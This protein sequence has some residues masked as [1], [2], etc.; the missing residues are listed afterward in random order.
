MSELIVEL[1]KLTLAGSIG[2]VA[3]CALAGFVFY[4][5]YKD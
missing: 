5:V 1:N 4:V 3:L 2:L